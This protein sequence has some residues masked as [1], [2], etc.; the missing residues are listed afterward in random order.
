MGV[1]YLCTMSLKTMILLP[2]ARFISNMVRQH[3]KSALAD[4]RRIFKDLMQDAGR[5][6]F[7]KDHNFDLIKNYEDFKRQVPVRDYEGL[8]YYFDRIVSGE[9]GVLWPGQP[10][11]LAKT[12]GTTSGIKYI[13]VSKQSV[14]NHIRSA[15][16]A[17]FNY[18]AVID[19]ASIFE[20]KMIFLSGSPELETKGGCPPA[21][22]QALLTMK[23]LPGSEPTNYQAGKPIVLK[24]GKK[25]WK[26]SSKKPFTRI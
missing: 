11:Y 5:T 14:P 16:N 18:M 7:G 25:N 26:L 17:I 23:C 22:C 10:K 4:Q 13:P 19:T 1:V 6:A 3:A 8:K 24:I 12:S 9:K 21:D 2:V 15:R 20:G